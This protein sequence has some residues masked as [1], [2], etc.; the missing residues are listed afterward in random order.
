MVNAASFWASHNGS[1]PVMTY[2]PIVGEKNNELGIA[3]P[4]S[5]GHKQSTSRLNTRLDVR[6]SVN[7]IQQRGRN[8]WT[9]NFVR[10]QDTSIHSSKLTFV[11][12]NAKLKKVNSARPLNLPKATSKVWSTLTFL[13]A[14][15]ARSTLG[16]C[17]RPRIRRISW[18]L[19]PTKR[20]A[21]CG[22]YR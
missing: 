7:T 17:S 2:F 13:R 10:E 9:Q 20:F 14:N 21:D 3:D 6:Q 18:P 5:N 11:C 15:S 8:Y 1:S 4:G 16:K 19:F 22:G 12:V